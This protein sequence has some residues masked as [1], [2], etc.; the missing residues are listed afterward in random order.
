VPQLPVTISTIDQ[1]DDYRVTALLSTRHVPR[2][3]NAAH[4]V[5]VL[6][7]VTSATSQ[8]RCLC[9]TQVIGVGCN[10]SCPLLASVISKVQAADLLI[11]GGVHPLAGVALLSIVSCAAPGTIPII[12]VAALGS[13]AR[14]ITRATS[15]CIQLRV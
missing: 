11:A 13:S 3:V 7:G 14:S 10:G 12:A 2:I 9:L 1:Y 4:P 15:C 6:P 8:S 5:F